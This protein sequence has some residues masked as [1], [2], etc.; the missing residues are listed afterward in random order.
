MDRKALRILALSAAAA[1]FIASRAVA[2]PVGA[3]DSPTDGQTVSGVVRVSGFVLDEAAIDKIG[4]LADGVPVNPAEMTLPRVDV[5]LLFPTYANS[6]TAQPGFLTSFLASGYSD[7]Q[8]TVAIR[9]TES[10][11]QAQTIVASVGV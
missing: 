9:V 3:I 5:L 4:V 7:G 6:P 2:Q 8:H 1:V 10:D 11:S